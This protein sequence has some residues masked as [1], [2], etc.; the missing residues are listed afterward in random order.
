ME[1]YRFCCFFKNFTKFIYGLESGLAHSLTRVPRGAPHNVAA[2]EQL[3]DQ[4]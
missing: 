4:P 3:L 2:L 1:I